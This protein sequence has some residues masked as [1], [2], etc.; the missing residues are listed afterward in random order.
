MEE[1][2]KEYGLEINDVRRYLSY[3]LAGRLR[4]MA[5]MAKDLED[6]IQSGKL[7]DELYNMEE[8]YL[9][10]LQEEMEEG[11]LDET[12]VREELAEMLSLRREKLGY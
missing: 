10:K 6:F 8:A 2:L 5:G 9:R 1:L 7:G 12:Y 4:E 3:L 11:T